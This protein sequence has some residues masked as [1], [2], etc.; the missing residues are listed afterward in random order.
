MNPSRAFAALCGIVAWGLL[1][2]KAASMLQMPLHR[3]ADRTLTE[4]PRHA[5]ER[6]KHRTIVTEV[7]H[8]LLLAEKAVGEHFFGDS[9]SGSISSGETVTGADVASHAVFMR[10]LSGNKGV[11]VISEEGVSEQNA[12]GPVQDLSHYVLVDPLDATREYAAGRSA[13][14]RLQREGDLTME[15]KTELDMLRYV[16]L[17]ACVVRQGSPV[18]GIVRFPFSGI[19]F[20]ASIEESS[21]RK[22]FNGT[23]RYARVWMSTGDPLYS[24]DRRTGE[25]LSVTDSAGRSMAGYEGLADLVRSGA[26]A[27]LERRL[28]DDQTQSG[29]RPRSKIFDC[30]KYNADYPLRLLVTRSKMQTGK[31]SKTSPALSLRAAIA[32]LGYRCGWGK[33]SEVSASDVGAPGLSNSAEVMRQHFA[34]EMH[35]QGFSSR[36]LKVTKAGGAGYKLA[37]IAWTALER[38]LQ[39]RGGRSKARASF[40]SAALRN[41]A[42]SDAYIHEGPIRTWDVCAGSV[43]LT[44][45]GGAVSGW[46]GQPFGFHPPRAR[47]GTNATG[48]AEKGSG[49][50]AFAVTG[51][52]AAANP[53][54]RTRLAEAVALDG[55][56]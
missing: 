32:S 29:E 49:K 22:G 50:S 13:Y 30:G 18:A 2:I 5:E 46:D 20:I 15:L 47:A 52:I 16:S 27:I 4:D 36:S 38:K 53:N 43:L 33:D 10:E 45:V 21:R 39:A 28:S 25:T 35:R 55:G 11:T 51:I 9:S 31:R 19:T 23:S 17:Q 40:D 12:G 7:L 37:S 54:A 3:P 6:M 41:L 44:A 42:Q 34:G 48:Q 1:I 24:F 8:S 14:R 26:G 56:V